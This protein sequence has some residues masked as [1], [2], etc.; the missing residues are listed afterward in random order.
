[1]MH[2]CIALT[3]VNNIE[4]QAQQE[5][6]GKWNLDTISYKYNY[7]EQKVLTESD[8][9]FALNTAM[10]SWDVEIPV[11]FESW[12]TSLGL[13]PHIVIDFKTPDEDQYFKDRPS[14]LAYAYFPGTQKQGEIVFNL[15]YIW[16]IH[17]KGVDAHLID[18]IH[19]KPNSGTL[20]KTW[21]ITHV[22][23]HELGHSIGLTHDETMS[24]QDVM[25]PYYSG[26]LELS[27]NDIKR[28]RAKY[29]NTDMPIHRYSRWKKFLKALMRRMELS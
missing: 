14:V 11:K 6:N 9:K 21:N 12:K 20:I 1:M 18:P 23:I 15:A 25:D 4:F 3:D 10:R 19:Y 29:G 5:W 22:L 27:A 24:T 17:G 8:L 7:R 2:G 28:V 16:S 26:M 13:P